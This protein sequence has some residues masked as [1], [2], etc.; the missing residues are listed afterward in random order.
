MFELVIMREQIEILFNFED[1]EQLRELRFTGL[2]SLDKALRLQRQDGIRED[3]LLAIAEKKSKMIAN[4]TSKTEIKKILSPKA[5]HFDGNKFIPDE[6]TLPEE[7]L[8]GW[9]RASLKAPLI[10]SAAK[11]FQEVFQ[12]VYPGQMMGVS[13]HV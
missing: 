4:A 1:T 7:E 9:S 10:D 5:P 8:I 11:R 3:L 6:Y 13:C 12:Q 2:R